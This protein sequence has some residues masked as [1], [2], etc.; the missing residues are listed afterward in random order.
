MKKKY[1]KK[2]FMKFNKKKIIIL[3]LFLLLVVLISGFTI[4]NIN[5]SKN[6]TYDSLVGTW[7][8]LKDEVKYKYE[9]TDD[10]KYRITN[11]EDNSVIEYNYKFYNKTD[12]YLY[13]YSDLSKYKN[14]PRFYEYKVLTIKKDHFIVYSPQYDNYLKFYSKLDDVKE[15]SFECKRPDINGYCIVDG[16]LVSYVGK[17]KKITIPENVHTINANAFASDMDRALNLLDITI[18]GTV[19]VIRPFAFSYSSADHIFIEEGVEYIGNYAFE[20]SC[21]VDI[22]FPKSIKSYGIH[23]FHVE[24]YCRDTLKVYLYK[25]T[26]MDYYFKKYKPDYKDV[27]LNYK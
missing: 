9:F 4:F 15:L 25:D 23:L 27:E 6:K 2:I 26:E 13:L 19:K 10:G 24:E 22:H 1:K 20:E 17:A 12:Y 16:F 11:L 14:V 3:C 5:S 18:P 21:L 8:V 7:Y